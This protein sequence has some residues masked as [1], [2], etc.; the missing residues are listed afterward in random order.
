MARCIIDTFVVLW[1]QLWTVDSY[2]EEL[3]YRVCPGTRLYFLK[4]IYLTYCFQMA[5]LRMANFC[6]SE[7][8]K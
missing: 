8:Q 3:D 2:D 6:G 5:M 1:S 7:W 4:I